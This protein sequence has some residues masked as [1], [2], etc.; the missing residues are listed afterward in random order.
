M[1][2]I[3][4]YVFLGCSLSKEVHYHFVNYCLSFIL[5]VS[6]FD[7]FVAVII[8]GR[9]D[10]EEGETIV[11]EGTVEFC[12]SIQYIKW[13]MWHYSKFIDVNIHKSKYNGTK[14]CLWSPKLVL[15]NVDQEDK[16]AYRIKVKSTTNEAYSNVHRIQI[17]PRNGK[18]F[19]TI[20]IINI[21]LWNDIDL[22]CKKKEC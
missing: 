16:G 3:C 9:T 1:E 14:N 5:E 7:L 13:Q 21:L 12:T 2:H 17:L 10:A 18:P 20:T 6:M 11:L 8:N 19:H 4:E 22:V 15:N